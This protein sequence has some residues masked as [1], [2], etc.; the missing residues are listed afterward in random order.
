MGEVVREYDEIDLPEVKPIIR[1]HRRMS[2][3]L[4]WRP[5]C[6]NREGLVLSVLFGAH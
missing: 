1:R 5:P 6:C 3:R 4:R 2:V